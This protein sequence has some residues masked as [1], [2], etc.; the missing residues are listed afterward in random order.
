[1]PANF[2][3][4]V[5]HHWPFS[6][7]L[8]F[9]YEIAFENDDVFGQRDQVLLFRIGLGILQNETALS[10]DGP[11]HFNNAIDFRD[12]SRIL[13]TTS[14]EKF[15]HSRQAAGDVFRLRHFARSFREYRAGAASWL[16]VH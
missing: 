2:K 1:R 5:R 13:A 14:F 16:F 11:A 8:T 6:H 9:L 15:R 10:A 3:N 12:L 7:L 4:L